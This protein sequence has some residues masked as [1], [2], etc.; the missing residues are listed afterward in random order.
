MSSERQTK[1]GRSSYRLVREQRMKAKVKGE[2][3]KHKANTCSFACFLPR[4]FTKHNPY[5]ISS[6]FLYLP[7]PSSTS[8]YLPRAQNN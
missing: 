8:L 5:L 3:R 4:Y 7:L 2:R 6:I 1:Y